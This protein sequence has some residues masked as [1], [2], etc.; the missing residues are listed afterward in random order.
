MPNVY[1]DIETY[2]ELDLK[3]VGVYAYTEHPSF[4]ILM[5]AWTV[6]DDPVWVE[7]EEDEIRRTLRDMLSLDDA[8]MVAHNANFERVC[9]SR[10]LGMPAGEY[11]D[12]RQWEDTQAI[13]AE[14]GYPQGLAALARALDG[15]QK[16]EAGTRLINL[17]SKPDRKGQRVTEADKPEEWAEFVAYCAQDVVTLRDV[18]LGLPGWPTRTERSAWIADALVNDR[19]I[20]VDLDMVREAI[21]AAE[22]NTEDAHAEMRELTEVSNPGSVVQLLAWL[23]GQG[24]KSIPDLRAETVSRVLKGKAVNSGSEKAQRVKRVLELR[25]EVALATGKKYRAIERGVS[26]D[27]RLRGQFRF[28]G[29]HTGRW[30]G[31]GAQLQNL[32]RKAYGDDLATE[33]AILDLVLGERVDNA[34]LKA[35][36]RSTFLLDGVVVDYSAIEARVIAWLAG[37]TWALDAFRAGRDIYTETADRMSQPGHPLTRQQGK[38]AVLA[39][40]YQGAVNSLRAMGGEGTDEE[41]R[42]QV[43]VWRGANPRIVQLWADL[44]NAFRHGGPAGRLRVEIDGR[45]RHIVLPSGR[46]IVYHNVILDDRVR[47]KTKRGWMTKTADTFSDPKIPNGRTLTY[48]GRLTE[49]ATQAVARDLLALALIRLEKAGF[50]VVG[51]VHD[52]AMVQGTDDVDAVARIMCEVPRWAE[53]LPVNGEGFRTF[54]YRKG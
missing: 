2:C 8:V 49:N 21:R 1:V 44:G 24:L 37:E 28:F 19:G 48:G 7:F 5:A 52:E 26:T 6:D 17:F 31:R 50:E 38:V 16:D 29:A 4:L 47:I 27:G 3:Q 54:R 10:L 40:G 53:G 22:E 46:A 42:H 43:N 34:S 9:F 20:R 14:N 45:D 35:L 30:S 15:E 18:H 23:H 36:V 25:Q 12:P 11:L 32:A 13:A 41:L 51:H 39:L 33:G